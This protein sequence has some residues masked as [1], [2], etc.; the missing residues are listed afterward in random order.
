[1]SSK[2]VMKVRQN[3]S[4]RLKQIGKMKLGQFLSLSEDK[5]ESYLREVE[6]DPLFQELKD[7][8]H[9]IGYKKFRDVSER[10]SSLALKEELVP[11]QDDGIDIE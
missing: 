10:P 11:Q 5:F 6:A 4:Q 3:L 2:H 8:Y 7:K 9:L 1:M